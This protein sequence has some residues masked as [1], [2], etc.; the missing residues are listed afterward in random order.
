[1]TTTLVVDSVTTTGDAVGPYNF[2]SNAS[3]FKADGG[4]PGST[5]TWL[6]N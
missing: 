4:I 2:T 6:K 3:A 5:V 1:V